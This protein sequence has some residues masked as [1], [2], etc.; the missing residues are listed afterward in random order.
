MSQLIQARDISLEELQSQFNLQLS[1][2]EDFFNELQIDFP[3]P[4]DFEKQRLERVRQNYLNLASRRS[5]SEEAVKMVVLSPLLDLAGF[6]QAPFS[7]QTEE[8]VEITA[9]D[10]GV[11]VRGSIDVLVVKQRFWALVIETKSK[12]FDV[13]TALPQALAYM[14]TAPNQ[15][16]PVYGLLVNGREFVFVKLEYQQTPI[17]ARSFALSIEREDELTQ[18]FR[19]LEVIRQKIIEVEP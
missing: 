15:E 12:Q 7:I 19:T 17:Y 5:F 16:L 4:T 1:S 9:E 8:S 13:L 3:E 6:F 2:I 10:E 14:L 11:V 18:V